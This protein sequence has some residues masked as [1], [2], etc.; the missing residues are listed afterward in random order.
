MASG[1]GLGFK[2]Q[3]MVWGYYYLKRRKREDVHS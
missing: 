2:V 3:D 1:S